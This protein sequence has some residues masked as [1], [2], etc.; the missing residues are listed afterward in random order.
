MHMKHSVI[1]LERTRLKWPSRLQALA[2]YDI[3]PLAATAITDYTT[4]LGK[5]STKFFVGA[6]TV[7]RF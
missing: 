7:V 2:V 1:S 6:Q 3:L 4:G 5:L